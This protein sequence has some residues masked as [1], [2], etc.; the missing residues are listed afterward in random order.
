MK[1]SKRLGATR[2]MMTERV[3]PRSTRNEA[4]TA[5]L[6]ATEQKTS[7]GLLINLVRILSIHVAELNE[8]TVVVLHGEPRFASVAKRLRSLSFCRARATDTCRRNQANSVAQA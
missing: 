6:R 2:A 5:A 4:D 3:E 1:P 7:A 8:W